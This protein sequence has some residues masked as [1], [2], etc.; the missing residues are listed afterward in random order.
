[1]HIANVT[2]PI[3]DNITYSYSN[4]NSLCFIIKLRTPTI[5]KSSVMCQIYLL[6]ICQRDA[7]VDPTPTAVSIEASLAVGSRRSVKTELQT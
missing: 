6:I 5:T 3:N 2:H 1:M 7:A 4:F